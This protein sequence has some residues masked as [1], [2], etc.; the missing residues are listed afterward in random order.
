MKTTKTNMQQVTVKSIAEN[1]STDASIA[2]TTNS[3][4][5]NT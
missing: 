1:L 2:N 5:T 3:I 4:A